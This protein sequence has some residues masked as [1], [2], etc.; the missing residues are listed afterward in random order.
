MTAAIKRGLSRPEYFSVSGAAGTTGVATPTACQARTAAIW[1]ATLP[2]GALAV[3]LL[4]SK[5]VARPRPRR[6]AA[7]R[8]RHLVQRTLSCGHGGHLG[9]ACLAV[10]LPSLA[11]QGKILHNRTFPHPDR[12][13]RL[14][15]RRGHSLTAPLPPQEGK[16]LGTSVSRLLCYFST[17]I[18]KSGTV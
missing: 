7:M 9:L 16:E 17:A 1:R 4:A 14:R 2:C 6:I 13:P 18:G 5:P 11:E 8:H 12:S 10:P 3:A 15:R